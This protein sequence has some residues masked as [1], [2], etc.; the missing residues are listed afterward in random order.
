MIPPADVVKTSTVDANIADE[1]HLRNTPDPVDHFH[2]REYLLAQIQSVLTEP[3]LSS[4]KNRKKPIVLTGLGGVGKTQ[5]ALEYARIHCDSY[6]TLFYIDATDESSFLNGLLEILDLIH[7]NGASAFPSDHSMHTR[8]LAPFVKT[9]L[10]HRKSKWLIIVDNFDKPE[11]VD[12]SSALPSS[13][14]G[15]VIV[16]SRRSDAGEIGHWIPVE[17]MEE[18]ESDEL[19]LKVAGYDLDKVSDSERSRARII[20]DY[21]GQLPLGL[22]LAGSFSHDPDA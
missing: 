6:K 19:L 5:T 2:G 15:D 12:L 7:I 16:A 11:D 22:E 1:P 21:V 3:G 18:E 8:K 20:S 17:P 14:L 4:S 9:W 13:A 10:S